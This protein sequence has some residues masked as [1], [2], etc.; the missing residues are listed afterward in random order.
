MA[1]HLCSESSFAGRR[2]TAITVDTRDELLS[3]S[4]NSHNSRFIFSS[5]PCRSEIHDLILEGHATWLGPGE[6][7]SGGTGD[8]VVWV[9]E[10]GV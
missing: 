2:F 9:Y 5:I 1:P 3:L 6:L 10:V 7:W 4:L 8:Y